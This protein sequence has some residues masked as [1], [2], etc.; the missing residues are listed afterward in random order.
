MRAQPGGG[1]RGKRELEQ[2]WSAISE[3]ERPWAKKTQQASAWK[4]KALVRWNADC[5][6]EAV[7]GGD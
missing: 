6:E 3:L 7:R 4:C 5:R 2:G 1:G